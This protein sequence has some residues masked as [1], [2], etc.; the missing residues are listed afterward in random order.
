LDIAFSS[1]FLRK[2]GKVMD[3]LESQQ[4]QRCFLT[5]SGVKVPEFS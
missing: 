2:K 3:G 5:A 1:V 4:Q